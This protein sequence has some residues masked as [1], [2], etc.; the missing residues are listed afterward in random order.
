MQQPG[1]AEGRIEVGEVTVLVC[2]E[3]GGGPVISSGQFQEQLVTE[4]GRGLSYQGE[5]ALGS[6]DGTG[7]ITVVTGVLDEIAV[8]H[9]QTTFRIHG[10][11]LNEIVEVFC[12]EETTD[13]PVL[14]DFVIKN[15][16]GIQ[17]GLFAGDL[18]KSIKTA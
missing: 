13:L 8:G 9:N 2:V 17:V 4:G 18:R 3:Q 15:K 6:A 10:L 16:V 11:T 5:H 1:C 12:A 14:V 7:R